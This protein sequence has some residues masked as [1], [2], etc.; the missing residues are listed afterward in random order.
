[1]IGRNTMP[2]GTGLPVLVT[3]D[4]RPELK[5]GAIT[6]DWSLVAAL[7]SPLTT[8]VEG[9][10]LPVGAKWLR[11]GQVVCKVTTA[12]AQTITVSGVPTGGSFNISVVRPDTGMSQ[13]VTIPFN[14]SVAAVQTLLD[15][16]LG[17]GNSVVSGAG[18]LPANVQT[19][20]AAGSL[21]FTVIPTFTLTANNLTGGTTPTAA[22]ATTA[23]A[24]SGKFGP[25]DS[26]ASDGRQTPSAGNCFIL[27]QTVVSGG[28]VVPSFTTQNTDQIG[29]AIFGG[30][31]WRNRII[32]NTSA[33][34]LAAGP[35][36][37]TLLGVLPRLQL[38]DN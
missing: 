21:L 6:L 16:V 4:G 11:F 12:N 32:A 7:G 14:A 35:L 29:G 10:Q 13:V 31:V 8:P 9:L 24:N 17:A 33:A 18:A 34:S 19:V 25:F 22:F 1:M 30:R 26:G 28:V 5:T 20:T 3:A 36:F 37:S 38:V 27:N 15:A 23:G 2:T